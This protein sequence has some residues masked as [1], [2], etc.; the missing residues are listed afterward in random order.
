MTIQRD[1]R[2]GENGSGLPFPFFHSLGA[3]LVV[4]VGNHHDSSRN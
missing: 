2:A 1:T 4:R 3:R